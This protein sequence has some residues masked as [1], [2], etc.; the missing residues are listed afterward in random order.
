MALKKNKKKQI[1]YNNYVEMF[2]TEFGE[3]NEDLYKLKTVVFSFSQVW[4]I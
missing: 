2:Q 4:Q 1:G 3:K